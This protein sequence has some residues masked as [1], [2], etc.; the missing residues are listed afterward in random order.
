MRQTVRRPASG[1]HGSRNK[2]DLRPSLYHEVTSRI[3]AELE[4]GRFPWVQPWGRATAGVGL[5]R[6]AVTGRR[7]SGVN[8]LILWGAVIE[9]GFLSQRWITF[10]QAVGTGG[11]VRKGERGT[12]VCYADRFIPKSEA[13]RSVQDG[14][15]PAAVAF[16]K[17]FSVF[18]IAQCEGLPDDLAV[19]AEP[20]PK[21]EIVPHAE[22]L[23]KA[24]GADFRI[25][26]EQAFYEPAHDFIQVPPQPAF[27]EQINYYRTCFHELGHWTGHVSRLGRDLSGRFGSA[28][29]ARE[30]LVAEMANAFVCASLN[31][32]PTVRHA[33][34]LGTWL[35]V[36]RQD[37]RAIFRA[38][39]QASK[40]A[41]FIL[42]SGEGVEPDTAEREIAA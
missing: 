24:T 15:E 23:I 21:C 3:V 2:D 38:A 35:D 1:K 31:I 37:D 41:D 30:E 42:G 39:S 10:K 22:R 9:K 6:N 32:L 29:Y 16:L 40:A 28:V 14:D 4:Q 36:L 20:L 34:Y 17:R 26:G 8:I 19:E 33:D 5:P 18:N 12:T 7:Y 27:H 11:S 13:E 25:G